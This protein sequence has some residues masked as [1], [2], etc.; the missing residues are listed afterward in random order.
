MDL[1][2]VF[3]T[4]Q[5]PRASV[6]LTAGDAVVTFEAGQLRHL[7]VAGTEAIRAVA[8]LVR[9]RDW[10]TVEPE[11]SDLRIKGGHVSY[12]ARYHLGT[13]VLLARIAIALTPDGLT[14]SVEAH[15]QGDVETNRAGFTVLHPIEGVAGAPLRVTHPQ[16]VEDAHFP[17][18]IAPWQPFKD[19]TA[20]THQAG[21]WRIDCRFQGDVFEMEDQR[22]WGDASF[23]TYNRP[24]S[25]PWPYTIPDGEALTQAVQIRWQAAPV[26]P[27]LAPIRATVPDPRFPETALALTAAEARRAARNPADLRGIGAQRVLCHMDA[28]AGGGLDQLR[29]FAALQAAL[30][31]LCYDL[32]LI[33]DC[34]PDADLDALF[35]G[36]AR[37]LAAAGLTVGSIMT[38]PAVD[39]QSTPPGSDWPACAPLPAIHAAARR[40]FAGLSVGGGMASF[41]PELNRKRPPVE[42]L[43]FVTH[44]L[45]PIVHAADDLSVMET[46]E[47]VPHILASAR[48]IIGAR[49]YRL[50]PSTIAMRQN[51]YGSRTIP[52]PHRERICMAEDDPR[53]DGTFA[54]AW[55]L[56]LA[57]AIAPAG[58]TVW[59]PAALYGPRGLIRD[60]GTWR[61]LARLVQEL[62]G[63]AGCPVR[64]SL[65]SSG[66]S[67][68]FEDRIITGWLTPTAP[69]PYGWKTLPVSPRS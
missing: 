38:C 45:C 25:L 4:D 3:G 34:P 7:R 56:G 63:Q 15:A 51:P 49:E 43:D 48:A 64:A 12:G 1:I 67:L 65:T 62:A 61:P 60:D 33:A 8:F 52:N 22:Q 57:A 68:A 20:L 28:A 58:V 42:L 30:P 24:L 13:G 27:P 19:I 23:K 59:T 18:L 47:T 26:A 17:T 41:F 37:D 69:D 35:A 46:L 54:A 16:G 9:D 32:E 21:G 39:R 44:G 6:Q 40:A 50:G 29:A 36:H 55:T 5:P 14:A 10:G 2:A 11:M 31:E 66:A 53:Q